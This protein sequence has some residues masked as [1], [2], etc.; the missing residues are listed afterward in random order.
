MG[1]LT[2]INK[3]VLEVERHFESLF[4]D[5]EEN[6]ESS[7][8]FDVILQYLQQN[9][10]YCNFLLFY[11]IIIKEIDEVPDYNITLIESKDED[12]KYDLFVKFLQ[13]SNIN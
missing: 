13:D 2:Y 7:L 10:E 5:D 11:V 6:E 3:I 1:A 12:E 8:C 4:E 9:M